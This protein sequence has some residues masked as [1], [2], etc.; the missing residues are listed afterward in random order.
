MNGVLN[1][2]LPNSHSNMIMAIGIGTEGAKVAHYLEEKGICDVDFL[3]TDQITP[4]KIERYRSAVFIMDNDPVNY[5]QELEK[6]ENG[7]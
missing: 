6:W 1:F 7:G 3:V 4:A 2:D 5:D